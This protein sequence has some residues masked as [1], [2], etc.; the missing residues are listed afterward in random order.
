MNKEIIDQAWHH[1]TLYFSSVG[2][3]HQ[4]QTVTSMDVLV[5]VIYEAVLFYLFLNREF[6]LI[7]LSVYYPCILHSMFIYFSKC[8]DAQCHLFWACIV[9][10]SSSICISQF[11]YLFYISQFIYLF[12]ISQFIY[13]L[14]VSYVI[15]FV[16]FTVHLFVFIFHIS[17]T[18]W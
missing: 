2:I 8:I 18:F 11:I 5:A 10:Q 12:Y 1:C 7:I 13:F 3:V 16:Y 9:A 6:I 14:Y 17:Y 4:R 15:Y